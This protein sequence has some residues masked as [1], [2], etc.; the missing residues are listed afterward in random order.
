M[1]RQKGSQVFSHVFV[2]VSDFERALR[3]YSALMDCLGLERRFC[4]RD[5]PWAGWHS[6][7][8]SRP[9]FVICKPYNGEPHDPGNGQM[10]AFLAC[11]RATVRKSYRIALE[12]GGTCEGPPGLR[13]HYHAEYYGAYFRDPDGNK[14]CVASHVA[15]SDVS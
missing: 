9:Y 7:G 3:F 2:S 11:D 6:A 4:E 5:K 10:L 12:L 15:E 8:Q 13:P 14:I 1:S